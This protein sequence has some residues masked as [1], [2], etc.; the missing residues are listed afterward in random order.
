LSKIKVRVVATLA[1]AWESIEYRLIPH[2]LASVATRKSRFDKAV[3]E[4]ARIQESRKPGNESAKEAPLWIRI[5]VSWLPAFPPI[6]LSS[7][8][9]FDLEFLFAARLVN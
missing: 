5:L 4:F 1:R 6:F 8:R 9:T 3:A 2:A 7:S